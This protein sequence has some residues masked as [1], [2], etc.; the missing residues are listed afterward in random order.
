MYHGTYTKSPPKLLTVVVHVMLAQETEHTVKPFKPNEVKPGEP[1][2]EQPEG[3]MNPYKPTTADAAI[4]TTASVLYMLLSTSLILINQ[5]I[6]RDDGF[7]YP[8][9]LTSLGMGFSA[10]VSF[11]VCQVCSLQSSKNTVSPK[12]YMAHILPVGLPMAL[13]MQFGNTAYLFLSI[14]LIEML[15]ACSPVIIMLGL[16]IMG[17]EVPNT[18]IV[19]AVL[20]I[21]V[22]T[23][24][25]SYGAANIDVL[26]IC[27]MGASI[28]CEAVRLVMTQVLLIGLDCNPRKAFP[29]GM[30]QGLLLTSGHSQTS[31]ELQSLHVVAQWPL[32]LLKFAVGHTTDGMTGIFAWRHI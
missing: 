11:I 2:G 24:M 3:S 18:R 1:N 19:T 5:R 22:G 17:L 25:A 31:Q 12:Y 28:V 15:K 21:V 29:C 26:G 4:I 7:H 30:P 32:S 13:S 14:S 20:V 23:L 6:M 10:A 16:F 9:A 8:M 27:Y